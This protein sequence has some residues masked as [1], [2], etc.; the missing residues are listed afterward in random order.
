MPSAAPQLIPLPLS[1]PAPPQQDVSTASAQTLTAWAQYSLQNHLHENAIFLA[2]RAVAEQACDASK[3][4]LATCHYSAGA[5]NRAVVILQGCSAPENRYLLALCC[6][7]LGRL[8]E[9][10]TALL[11]PAMPDTEATAALPNGA[12]GLYL[13]GIICLKMQQRQR[14]TKYLTR[15]LGSNPFMW[16]AH[17][18]LSQLGAALPEGLIAPPPPTFGGDGAMPIPALA[19]APPM[20]VPSTATMTPALPSLTPQMR[21]PQMPACTPVEAV[22]A[23]VTGV[24]HSAAAVGGVAA[25]TRSLSTLNL[26][27]PAGAHTPS[28]A[29]SPTCGNRRRAPAPPTSAAMPTDAAH[30]QAGSGTP[31]GLGRRGR[32]LGSSGSGVPVRRSSRLSSAGPVAADAREM[33]PPSVSRGVGGSTDGAQAALWLLHQCARGY[34]SLCSYKCHDAVIA[35]RALPHRQ[36]NTGWVLN[37]ARRQ[38]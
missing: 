21:T 25:D 2:E 37:Q 14:A 6:M 35:F 16:S 12:A 29:P 26:Q 3:L 24:P 27:T 10:Q 30:R 22:V 7:R 15:C 33:P 9:A 17:E 23:P 5:A 13:V 20:D 31:H 18:A 19:A 11:G 36:Y 34:R 32:A 1:T 28:S 38:C 8:P 4:L